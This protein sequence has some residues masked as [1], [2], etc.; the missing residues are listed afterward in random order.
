MKLRIE[1]IQHHR[2]GVGGAPF[3][4]VLFQD[5]GE[6]GSRKVAIVF[7]TEWHTAILDVTKLAS[8]DVAFGSNSW[9]GDHYEPLLRRS[10]A[11]SNVTISALP[12]D[13]DGMNDKRST[14]AGAA[15]SAFQ[16][17][18]GTDDDSVLCDLL[19]DLM[20]WADRN[21]YDFNAFL[22]ESREHYKAET[23][24]ESL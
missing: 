1:T 23:K 12:P 24:G 16:R 21:D 17:A 15:I 9:R 18:T 14:W 4:V 11:E 22:D 2:N 3:H 6:L 10:I 5:S 7:D 8:G 13:P 19:A 20:H